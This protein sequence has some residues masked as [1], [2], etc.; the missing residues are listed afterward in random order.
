[1]RLILYLGKG[2]VG[3]T[4]VAAATGL[5]CARRGYKSLIASTDIAHSLADVL[6]RHLSHEPEAVA[7]N[8]WAEEINVFD[9]V[10]SHWQ[11]LQQYFSRLLKKRGATQV[12]AEELA[13][14]PGMEE[15]VSLLRILDEERREHYDVMIVDAAPTGETIRLLT[16]PESFSW[17]SGRLGE[18][19]LSRLTQA[20]FML[21]N[22]QV[23]QL[24]RQLDQDVAALRQI[25][26]DP[27][28][29]S[30]RLVVTPEKMVLKE[31]MRAITYLS[32]YGYPVDAAVINRILPDSPSTDPYL[33]QLKDGQKVYLESIREALAPLPLFESPWSSEEVIGLDAISRLADA[34]WGDTDPAQIFRVG[35]VQEVI[36]RQGGYV[37][38]LPFPYQDEGQVRLTKRGDEL[39]IVVGSFKREFVLPRVLAMRNASKADL[40]QDDWLEIYFE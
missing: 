36:E 33:Q 34:L 14:I 23:Y 30:Y 32:L 24:L 27:Q 2:G 28:T 4:T 7:E 18:D 35:P 19:R 25:L 1:M 12:I 37:L 13:I 16:I 31:T 38:R 26:R 22:A 39:F 20:A 11:D 8:L 40:T 15:I 9:Q 29:S 6:N 3:K 10:Q 5:A 21:P 17:Y